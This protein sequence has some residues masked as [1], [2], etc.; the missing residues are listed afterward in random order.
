VLLHLTLISQER[1][2]LRK[3]HAECAQ[4]GIGERVDPIPACSRI[5]Q[6]ATGCGQNRSQLIKGKWC[7]NRQSSSQNW[8][9]QYH[10]S[11][12]LSHWELLVEHKR[13]SA[14]LVAVE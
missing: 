1:G 5:G 11:A 9:Q 13:V 7:W 14:L 10:K 8:R 3:E 6:P 4:C 12:H 2:R